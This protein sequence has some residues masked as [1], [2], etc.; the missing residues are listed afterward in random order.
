MNRSN[1]RRIYT[2]ILCL[3]I[4]SYGFSLKAQSHQGEKDNEVHYDTKEFI[5][6]HLADAYE[7]HITTFKGKHISLPLPVIVYGEKGWDIFMSSR[8]DHGHQEYN[9]Y[10]IAGE[11][12]YKGKIVERDSQ[13]EQVRPWDISITKNALSLIINSIILLT[14]ILSLASFYK[15]QSRTHARKAPRGFRGVMEV[16]IL[17]IQDEVIKPCVGANYAR[18]SPYLLTVFFFILI[19][20]LVGL[21]PIFPGGANVTGNIAVTMILALFTFFYI[22]VFGTREYWKE[23]FWPDV[24]I[25]LRV[26]PF[27]AIIEFISVFTK[28]FALMIRLFANVLAGHSI[29]ISLIFLIFITAKEGVYIN[30]SMTVVG[31]LLSVFMSLLEV[32]ISFIQAYVFTILSAVFIGSA[33]V[34]HHG[35]KH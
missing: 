25:F 13:G 15:Q 32:L 28:P 14:I 35:A 21:I 16:L 18:F 3:L 19:N 31:M 22:N 27:V 9:G 23:I 12:K 30:T 34:E 24:P 11:G 20:N 5:L 33:Q 1:I 29:I 10:F 6:E 17:H 4:G 7:W 8:L 26:V 2:F